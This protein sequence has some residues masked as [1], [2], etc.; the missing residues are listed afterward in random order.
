ML[1]RSFL[2]LG[3][4]EQLYGELS[5]LPR[6]YYH[7]CAANFNILLHEKTFIG[8]RSSQQRGL[9][10]DADRGAPL[11]PNTPVATVP[12]Q[13]LYRLSNIHTKPNALRAIQLDDVRAAIR[14]DEMKMMAPQLLL[15]L[16]FAAIITAL[17]D[18]TKESTQA[19]V[20]RVAAVLRGGANPWAR[21][22]DDEDFNEQFIL[23]MY[24]MTLDTWQRASYDQ[25]T[26]K[27]HHA[28]TDLHSTLR[29]PYTIDHLRRITRLVLARAEHVPP[30]DYYDGSALARRLQRRWRQLRRR[31]D[32]AE[33]AMVPLLDMVNH[34]NRPNCGVRVGP[35]PALGGKG[36]I[37]LFTLTRVE[38]GHE[39]CRHYNFALSRPYA[40]FRYGFL[41]FDLISIVEHDAVQEHYVKHKG[42]MRPESEEK[43]QQRAREDR[44]VARLEQIFKDA[45]RQSHLPPD[46]ALGERRSRREPGQPSGAA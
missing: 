3:V 40:L 44:E 29:L 26:E 4:G 12:L 30:A 6:D 17:P 21:M 19:D 11:A 10:L 27:F 5:S 35:S 13:S 1:R 37:T 45:R 9:F 7:C 28:L 41:P 46:P 20:E 2:L 39:L 34:S 14:D 32:P 36:A 42:S 31:P 25:L 24:G 15:G 43:Q 38:P 33:V 22:L 18:I 8:I 23:G 16:Q